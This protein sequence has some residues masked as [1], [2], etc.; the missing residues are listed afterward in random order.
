M[1]ISL[2]RIHVYYLFF[3]IIDL[4]CC[5]QS[6]NSLCREAC[7]KALKSKSSSQEILDGLQEGGCGT[8]LPHD[9]LWQCFLRAD[10]QS[11]KDNE[12]NNLDRLGIDSA[13]LH[14]CHKVYST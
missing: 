2:K 3:I 6:A 8:P 14:C 4:H 7:R 13:K 5:E 11:S 10:S 12:V 9:P 1:Y